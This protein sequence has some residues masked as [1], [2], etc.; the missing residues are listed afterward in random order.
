MPLHIL[1]L[2]HSKKL[3]NHNSWLA[4]SKHKMNG[5]LFGSGLQEPYHV[6]LR[7][8]AQIRILNGILN[9]I[10]CPMYTVQYINS[11]AH[12]LSSQNRRFCLSFICFIEQQHFRIYTDLL[13]IWIW[14][15]S[16]KNGD[17][18]KYI[19]IDSKSN[20]WLFWPFLSTFGKQWSAKNMTQTICNNMVPF[21]FWYII[22]TD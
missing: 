18:Q 14:A 11:I 12:I 3:H 22:H 8:L 13:L 20:F 2:F 17:W 9:Y 16:V 10:P 4:R 7:I 1:I 19:Y 21:M 15:K 6:N 5:G